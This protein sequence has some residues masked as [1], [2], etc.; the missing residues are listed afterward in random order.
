MGRSTPRVAVTGVAVLLLVAAGCSWKA[1]ELAPE[2]PA[3]AQSSKIYAADGTLIKTLHGPQN[4]VEV[5]L[6]T[7]PLVVQRAVVAIEDERF[8]EHN[9]VDVRAVLRAAK[10]NAEQ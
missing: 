6:S 8:Y 7:I 1:T 3:N 4:R 9:G 5:P 10:E 2:I